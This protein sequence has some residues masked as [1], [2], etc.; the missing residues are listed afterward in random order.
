MVI[1]RRRP[2]P[3]LV[4]HSDRGSRDA[5]GDYRKISQS[6]AI[7]RSMSRG[8]L[9]GQDSDGELRRPLK[10]NSCTSTTIPI[11]MPHG[12]TT[13]I[14]SGSTPLSATSLRSKQTGK[15]HNPVST[16]P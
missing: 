4:H 3:G 5:A 8:E 10:P 9:L 16:F 13:T 1:Q 7:L 12:A 6:A 15:P 11:A 2:E 14:G